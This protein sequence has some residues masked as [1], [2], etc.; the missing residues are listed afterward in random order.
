MTWSWCKSHE[1]HGSAAVNRKQSSPALPKTGVSPSQSGPQACC[2]L[3][4]ALSAGSTSE[5]RSTDASSW[6]QR[7]GSHRQTL[8]AGTFSAGCLWPPRLLAPEPAPQQAQMTA[9]PDSLACRGQQSTVTPDTC[10]SRMELARVSLVRVCL[11]G[12]SHQQLTAQ[13]HYR[14][15]CMLM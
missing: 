13:H 7:P 8:A 11:Q 6:Q 14:W 10:V 5:R 4:A 15:R 1:I 3:S 9:D 2:L 12:C